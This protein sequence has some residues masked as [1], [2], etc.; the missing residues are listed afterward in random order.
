MKAFIYTKEYCPYCEVAKKQLKQRGHELVEVD[1][2]SHLEEVKHV[3]N[4]FGVFKEKITWPQ[5]IL[6]G[7]YIGGCDDLLEFFNGLN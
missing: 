2:P 5:I 6:D 1:G 7:S 3:L 4:T